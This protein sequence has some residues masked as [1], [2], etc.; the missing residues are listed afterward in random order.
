[1]SSSEMPDKSLNPVHSSNGIEDNQSSLPPEEESPEEDID[2]TEM[3]PLCMIPE[4]FVDAIEK[5]VKAFR[6]KNFTCIAPDST[7][8]GANSQGDNILNNAI[9][10]FF[11]IYTG[12]PNFA[13]TLGQKLINLGVDVDTEQLQLF[14]RAVFQYFPNT[15]I[16]TGCYSSLIHMVPVE[17]F[18]EDDLDLKVKVCFNASV[19]MFAIVEQ[20]IKIWKLRFLTN[21]GFIASSLVLYS[22]DPKVT[23]Q[24]IEYC[25]KVYLPSDH[26]VKRLF[27]DGFLNWRMYVCLL[28]FTTVYRPYIGV[29]EII[30]YDI[31]QNKF[32][33]TCP[34]RSLN[35]SLPS[36]KTISG[37]I[38][39]QTWW[40]KRLTGVFNN[41]IVKFSLKI[42]G[43]IILL[44]ALYHLYCWFFHIKPINVF[45]YL[46]QM[47][48]SFISHNGIMK[49]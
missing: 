40:E 18:D 46:W 47:F 3:R 25:K 32:F 7:Q 4:E 2:M 15:L 17:S 21:T 20:A 41:W 9:W 29:R 34:M 10:Q 44:S 12:M 35:I 6:E 37:R 42:I 14:S 23:E 27:T 22:K 19:W 24:L 26:I 16:R 48:G 8:I 39:K 28:T 5:T 31:S 36:Y 43:F 49:G 30:V 38:P 13:A 45:N 1:M 11:K 33:S